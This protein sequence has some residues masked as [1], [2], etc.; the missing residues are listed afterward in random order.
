LR[1]VGVASPVAADHLATHATQQ[2][3]LGCWDVGQGATLTLAPRG[4]HSVISTARFST[5]PRGGPA[6]RR[7]DGRWVAREQAYALPCRPTSQH[8]SVCLVRP[9]PDGLAVRVVAFGHGGKVVG[10]VEDFVASR[11]PTTP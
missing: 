10:V 5:R 11:C 1:G 6:T 9:A 8:G 3:V 4:K 2:A 7:E